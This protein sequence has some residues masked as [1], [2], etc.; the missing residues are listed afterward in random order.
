MSH[1]SRS[2]II[3]RDYDEI[4]NNQGSSFADHSYESDTPDGYGDLVNEVV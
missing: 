4:L 2:H 3:S 1:K